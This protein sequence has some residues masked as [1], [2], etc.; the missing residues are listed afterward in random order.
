MYDEEGTAPMSAALTGDRNPAT[1]DGQG[2]SLLYRQRRVG[3]V[4]GR[5]DHDLIQDFEQVCVMENQPR[6]AGN[7]VKPS[8]SLIR[9]LGV[10]W[11]H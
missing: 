2:Y 5:H 6:E 1:L 8:D 10:D 9:T 7:N 4:E 3:L 11:P